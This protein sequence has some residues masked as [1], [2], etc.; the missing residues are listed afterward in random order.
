MLFQLLFAGG[1]MGRFMIGTGKWKVILPLLSTMV[2]LSNLIIQDG[3]SFAATGAWIS[4]EPEGVQIKAQKT[5]PVTSGNLYE[6]T[7]VNGVH[8][9]TIP[10]VPPPKPES[11]VP[12]PGNGRVTIAW[13]EVA[14]ATSY[15]LYYST[16][17]GVDKAT[18]TRITGV[19]RPCTVSPLINGTAYYFVVTAVNAHGESA[20]SDQISAVPGVS[21]AAYSLADLAGFWEVNSLASGPGAPWWIRI[22]LNIAADGSFNGTE[23]D[24]DG[25]TGSTFG[26]MQISPN[27]IVTMAGNSIFQCSMDS[28]KTLLACTSTWSGSTS[29][30]TSELIQITKKGLGYSSADM[31]GDWWFSNLVTPGP[32]WER[33]SLAV[34]SNGAFTYAFIDS[35]SHSHIGTGT[36]GITSDGVLTPVGANI[37][38]TRCVMDSGKSV[39]VCTSTSGNGDTG[40]QILTRKAANYSL[41]DLTGTWEVN[42][43]VSGP[44]APWWNRGS[45]T[46]AADGSCSGIL[47]EN[48]GSPPRNV[49]GTFGIAANGVFTPDFNANEE[50]YMDAGKTI[51]ACT[52][53]WTTGSPGSTELTVLTKLMASAPTTLRG[54]AIT[55]GPASLFESNAATY[56]VSAYWSDGSSSSVAPTWSVTPTSYAT[57]NS[58]TGQLT[59]LAVPS[60]LTVTVSAVYTGNGITLTASKTVMIVNRTSA[61]TMT[62]SGSGSG[63]I[64]SNPAGTIACT[65]PPQSGTCLTSLPVGTALTLI[66]TPA[67]DSGFDSWGSA[68]GSCTGLSCLLNIDSDK[69]CSAAFQIRP[70]VRIAGPV[71]FGSIIKAYDQLSEGSPASMLAQAVELTENADLNKDIQLT[72]QGGYDPGFNT[73]IG[74]TTLH[75]GLTVSRGSLVV[76][77]LIV[78]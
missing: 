57:I 74:F 77:R 38:P 72:L 58:S 50:C 73:R 31:V 22:S 53:T 33:G 42:A 61:L 66:A 44:G 24:S 47:Q 37:S 3:I 54:L 10:A 55:S 49:S 8:S 40:L 52:G 35:D 17:P 15:N 13:S 34:G 23:T 76:D 12:S 41:N 45:V 75:G 26:T 4:S 63:S 21:S 19:T 69:S 9:W 60:N 43:M 32:K 25:Y 71:Y 59:T 70:L 7:Y 1:N 18:G 62:L 6:G 2:L 14:E 46:F 68:C 48:D 51:M 20:E 27:G 5:D 65:Y 30:G 56:A 67:A 29:P 11:V 39:N 16:A 28:G 78:W 64:N 36:L